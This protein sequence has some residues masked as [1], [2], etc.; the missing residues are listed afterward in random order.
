L[1][2]TYGTVDENPAFW[3][4]ISS[5]SYVAN[6]SGPVQLH[7]ATTDAVVPVALSEILYG[8]LQAAGVPAELYLYEGD[9][10][11]IYANFW[12]AMNR[13]IAF[14]DAYLKGEG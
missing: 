2:D 1:I 3:A 7:H 12:T 11:N 9:N 6:L 8:E 4:A 13:S 14:F 10:H 5:N